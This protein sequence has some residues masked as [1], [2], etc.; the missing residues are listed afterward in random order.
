MNNYF[1]F[2]DETGEILYYISLWLLH[3][4]YSLQMYSHAATIAFM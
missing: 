2:F 3:N 1:N 4:N